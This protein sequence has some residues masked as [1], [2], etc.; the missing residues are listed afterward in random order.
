MTLRSEVVDCRSHR[1]A[2]LV[3]GVAMILRPSNYLDY[4]HA[5]RPI[6]RRRLKQQ[7]VVRRNSIRHCTKVL[8]RLVAERNNL[9]IFPAR[10]ACATCL[11]TRF[12]CSFVRSASWLTNQHCELS[13]RQIFL[14]AKSHP[15]IPCLLGTEFPSAISRGSQRPGKPRSFWSR[16]RAAMTAR[17]SAGCVARAASQ[18]RL[19]MPCSPTSSRAS[20]ERRALAMRSTAHGSKSIEGQSA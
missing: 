7:L 15:E 3:V 1:L 18:G 16:A 20:T 12:D 14:G 13:R 5:P 6:S 9:A 2:P 10:G 8:R 4:E 19:S 17:P 11:R